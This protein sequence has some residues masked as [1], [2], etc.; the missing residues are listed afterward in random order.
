MTGSIRVEFEGR[1]DFLAGH[2]PHRALDAR[3]AEVDS[4]VGFGRYELPA[5]LYVIEAITPD[6]ER[7]SHTV[8]LREGDTETVTFGAPGDEPDKERLRPLELREAFNC[9]VASE[10]PFRVQ[11][12][13]DGSID[14]TPR[15]RFGLILVDAVVSLPVHDRTGSP[16]DTAIVV[17]GEGDLPVVRFDPNRRVA[18]A[19]DNMLGSGRM[20]DAES[21][22]GE[23]LE[24]L[25]HK[26]RDPPAAALGALTLHRL[27]RLDARPSWLR[28]LA[29]SFEWLPDGR[30][31]LAAFLRDSDEEADRTE[32]LDLLLEEPLKRPL[33]S[34]GLS[35]W[36]EL[37]RR[38]PGD[39]RLA[40]RAERS[41]VLARLAAT[42][43]LGATFLTTIA[44]PDSER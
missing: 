34:D 21:V 5:G 12:E 30:V 1:S 44:S 14:A 8:Q 13:H 31:L 16:G 42:A 38:W 22:F 39:D 40:E 25:Y 6:G 10:G 43:D 15:A 17:A 37:L 2:M 20:L 18:S 3:L 33:Y 7:E 23:A 36:I 11:F 35:L 27:G 4:R 9:R 26:Y 32:G 24:L 29:G 19:I 41:K 28:N